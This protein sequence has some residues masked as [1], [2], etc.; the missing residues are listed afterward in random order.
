MQ[1]ILHYL[2]LALFIALMACSPQD[3]ALKKLK[4]V[5]ADGTVRHE[6][7]VETADT[8]ETLQHGLMGRTHLAHDSG[9]IF[10]TTIVPLDIPVIMWMKD[11]LIPLDM[12]FVDDS[13]TIFFI[14]ENAQPNDITPIR[15]PKRPQAVLELNAGQVRIYNI[16]VGDKVKN[17]LLN[18]L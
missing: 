6:Y 12:V 7:M 3:G 8:H 18:N 9:M 15:S 4:I 2:V 1:K 10:D 11:T 5:S 13:G 14:Y 16:Q 17:K